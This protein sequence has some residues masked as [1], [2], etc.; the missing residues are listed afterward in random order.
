VAR[1][2]QGVLHGRYARYPALLSR[3]PDSARTLLHAVPAAVTGFI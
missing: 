2:E 3:N 1:D